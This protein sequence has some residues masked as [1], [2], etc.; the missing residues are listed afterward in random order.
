MAM[1]MA[2]W[3]LQKRNG[4]YQG[5]LPESTQRKKKLGHQTAAGTWFC[6][7]GFLHLESQMQAV[8]KHLIGSRQSSDCS[9]KAAQ[10]RVQVKERAARPC[11]CQS[12]ALLAL[13][14]QWRLQQ[15]ISSTEAP[16]KE[17]VER[18]LAGERENGQVEEAGTLRKLR[19]VRFRK[20]QL[21][22]RGP[23]LL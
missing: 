7:V 14:V 13:Y 6:R 19:E 4:N 23:K 22:Q 8:I 3:Q 15:T 1:A 9:S 10:A 18:V 16:D 2:R 5:A 21:P 12:M 17:E 20:I 11:R